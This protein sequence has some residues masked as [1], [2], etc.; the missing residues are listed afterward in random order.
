MYD[1]HLFVL[2]IKA[3]SFTYTSPADDFDAHLRS[4]ESLVSDPTKQAS[5]FVG[6]LNSSP[7]VTVFDG[8][9]REVD[10]LRRSDWR[11][12]TMCAVSLDPFTELAAQAQHLPKIGVDLGQNPVW[13]LSIDDLRV[14]ADVFRN[15]LEFLHYVEHRVKAFGTEQLTLDDELDHLG[16]YLG[17]NDYSGMAAETDH[18]FTKIEFLGYRDSIDRYF[19]GKL[20][21][22]DE[23]DAPRSL[24]EYQLGIVSFELG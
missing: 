19:S 15:P 20:Q 10:R 6:Y 1:D 21:S 16:L 11:R 2:E 24:S 5:R 7:Q 14:Y 13:S 23:P 8:K 17:H 4:L 22:D 18:D 3:G 9:H 12:V